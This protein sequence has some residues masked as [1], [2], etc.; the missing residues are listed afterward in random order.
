MLKKKEKM[1]KE[2]LVEGNSIVKT[3]NEL[4]LEKEKIEKTL[5]MESTTL[6]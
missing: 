4:Y 3:L 5:V 1:K 6:Y 2:D